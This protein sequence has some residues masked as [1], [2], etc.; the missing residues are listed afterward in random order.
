MGRWSDLATWVGPTPNQGGA[1]VQH[2]YVVLHIADGTYD[3]TIAWQ[4]NADANVSSHFIVAK[5]GRVAQ[6]VDTDRQA[7]TQIAGNPYSI[8]V[9]NEGHTGDQL[10]AAQVK[11]CSRIFERA[12][13]EHGIPLQVTSKVGTPGLA[14]HSMGYESGVNWGHQFCPGEPIKAQ[15]PTIVTL[16]Q[17][18]TVA[19]SEDAI[20]DMEW[21]EDAFAAMSENIRGGRYKGNPDPTL[22][23]HLGVVALNRIEAKLDALALGGV[24]VDAVATAVVAKLKADSEFKQMLVDAANQAEDT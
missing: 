8:S 20:A 17:G 11:A 16:A 4:K 6:M 24:D 23:K 12:H 13:R 22:G 9:E 7:W 19:I 2:L 5:D 1:I 15:K 3:G 10:T 21:R 14:H 18:G